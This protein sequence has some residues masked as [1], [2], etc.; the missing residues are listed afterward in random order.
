MRDEIS[1]LLLGLQT[2]YSDSLIRDEVISILQ[3]IVPK[4][5]D[6]GNGRPGMDLWAILV[7]GT[8]RLNCNWDYDKL[9]NI[10][11]N[12]KTVREF[13]G[14]SIVEFDQTIPLQTYALQTLKENRAF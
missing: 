8:L 2:I 12:H 5:V 10:A 4:D 6:S 7:L 14:H 3:G 11:N 1:Q 13:L 9:H